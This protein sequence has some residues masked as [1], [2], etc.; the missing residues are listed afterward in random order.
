[1]AP[2]WQEMYLIPVKPWIVNT[3]QVVEMWPIVDL[4]NYFGG[5]ECDE[6]LLW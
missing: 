1:M 3:I 4:S 2:K 5:A 6:L